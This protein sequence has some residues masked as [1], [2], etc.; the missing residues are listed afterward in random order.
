M[1]CRSGAKVDATS[2]AGSTPLAFAVTTEDEEVVDALISKYGADP[3]IPDNKGMTPLAIAVEARLPDIAQLLID[4]GAYKNGTPSSQLEQLLEEDDTTTVYRKCPLHLAAEVDSED[5]IMLL[6]RE[7]AD[8]DGVDAR[9]L[10][11]ALH[12]AVR[13][14]CLRAVRVLLREGAN[15]DAVDGNGETPLHSACSIGFAEGVDVLIEYGADVNEKTI[16]G[17]TALSLAVGRPSSPDVVRMLVRKGAKQMK[18]R[19]GRTALH[20]GAIR[21]ETE[22]LRAMLEEQ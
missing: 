16:N 18:N 10:S 19:W 3:N 22:K 5:M 17:E 1:L 2:N 14:R 4:A 7:Q 9:A 11:T 20:L 6:L 21:G 12:H 8:I 15:V 13:Q